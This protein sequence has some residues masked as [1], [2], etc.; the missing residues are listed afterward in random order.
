MVII[1]NIIWAIVSNGSTNKNIEHRHNDNIV[2][3]KINKRKVEYL[4]LK[5]SFIFNK[6]SI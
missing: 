5:F 1:T 4:K 2:N 6:T 3:I